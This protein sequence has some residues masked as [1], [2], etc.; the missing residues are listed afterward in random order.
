MNRFCSLII[1]AAHII[2]VTTSMAPDS[3]MHSASAMATARIE[4]DQHYAE[5]QRQGVLNIKRQIVIKGRTPDGSPL[6]DNEKLVHLV[7]HGQG[8]HNLLGD[9]YRDFGRTVDSTG[10]DT[11]DNPYTRPEIED[12][13]LTAVGRAQARGLRTTVQMLPG[14]ELVVASPLRRAIETAAI[15]FQSL[16]KRVK[17]IGHPGCQETS[18]VNICDRR[19]PASEI[20]EDFPWVDWRLLKDEH[21]MFFDPDRRESARSVSDRAYSF[22]LWLRDRG[23]REIA[24][25]THS[26]WLFTLLNTVVDCRES[27]LS[28]WF[29][30][31]ELRSVIISWTDRDE[32]DLDERI[33]EEFGYSYTVPPKEEREKVLRR[34]EDDPDPDKRAKSSFAEKWQREHGGGL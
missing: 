14:I 22:M 26:A 10:Q 20:R 28:N 4:G 13:P 24:V 5:L 15:G 25:A 30:T 7:R 31:G 32:M 2:D 9:L 34:W 3:R 8:F 16:R 11:D 18:G 12:S 21:D 29:L 23:E 27:D 1:M 19:R 33:K 6:E 17:W